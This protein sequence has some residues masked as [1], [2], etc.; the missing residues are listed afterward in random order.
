MYP[1][2]SIQEALASM[3]G[4]SYFSC[5]DCQNA[6]MA[7][8]LEEESKD[9]TGISTTCGSFIFNRLPFG[10]QGGTQTYSQAIA[11]ALEKLPKGVAMPYLDDSICPASSF[12]E[13]IR[14]LEMVFK[15]L[16]DAGII[17]SARKTKLFRDKVDYL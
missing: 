7:V 14:N 13:M 16:G 2:P 8:E 1:L 11:T 4:Y 12:D 5:I 17:I 15:A 10:L 9:L 3:A 6:Y